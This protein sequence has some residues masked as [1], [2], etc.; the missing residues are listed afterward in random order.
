M[1]KWR[2]LNQKPFTSRQDK[3]GKKPCLEDNKKFILIEII[4][5]L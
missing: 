5:H 3:V 2:L 1:N 4:M